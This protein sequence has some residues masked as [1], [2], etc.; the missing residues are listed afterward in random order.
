MVRLSTFCSVSGQ[1]GLHLVGVLG[2]PFSGR[3][4]P[5]LVSLPDLGRGTLLVLSVVGIYCLVELVVMKV[6]HCSFD[7]YS[8]PDK[9]SVFTLSL[10]RG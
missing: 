1:L 4:L 8:R 5:C 9:V 7:P 6:G 10:E 3:R 2:S